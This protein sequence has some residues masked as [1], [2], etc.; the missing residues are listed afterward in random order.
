[1]SARFSE[2]YARKTEAGPDIEFLKK[3]GL[4]SILEAPEGKCILIK[5]EDDSPDIH[6]NECQFYSRVIGEAVYIAVQENVGLFHYEHW[7][8]G[9]LLRLLSYNSDYNWH[10][11]SGD[12]EEWEKEVLFTDEKLKETLGCYDEESHADIQRAWEEKHITEGAQFPSINE[13]E[14]CARLRKKLGTA[15]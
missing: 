4:L 9:Q 10:T 13:T 7:K 2:Y 15:Y 5:S 8:E 3:N 6:Q 11:V 12:P 14:A 1:M